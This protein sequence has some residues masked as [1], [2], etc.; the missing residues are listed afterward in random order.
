MN[1][2]LI[3]AAITLALIPIGIAWRLAPLHLA[4][5]FYKYGGSV[6]W[7]AMLYW[8][9]A[10]LL[11]RLSPPRVAALA[12]LIATLVECSRLVHTPALD[13]FRT[14]LAGKLLLGRFF[15]LKNIAAYWLAIL[16]SA[17][18]DKWVLSKR[19]HV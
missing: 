8:L 2:R 12:A 4:P 11:P 9:A 18:L 19:R 3:S 10:A 14:T 5:F 15:S 7:A 1:R 17:A 13:A 16:A 6:F